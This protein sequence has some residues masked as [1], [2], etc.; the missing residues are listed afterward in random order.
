MESLRFAATLVVVAATALFTG[1]G[2][3]SAAT[4]SVD[5]D[6][7]DCPAADFSHVQAA[8]DAAGTGDT[9]AICPGT[10]AEGPG[11]PG[12]NGVTI[13]KS[14]QI[15]GA[16]ADLVTIEPRANTQAGGQIAANSPDL[17]DPVGNIITV[18]G[19][20]AFP[21]T[22]DISGVT[23]SGG[24]R[25]T[26]FP[27]G[28]NIW[29][30]EFEGGVY[31]EAGILY[32]DA[33]G[34]ISASRVTNVV[35]SERPVAESQPGGYRS[36]NLGYGIAQ[37]TAAT[38]PPLGYTPRT[39]DVAGTRIDRYNKGGLL[40]DSATGDTPPLTASGVENQASVVG[41]QIIGRNLNSPP[42]DGTG[43]GALLTT[44]TLF[45][46]DGVKV[47]AGASLNLDS[48]T[49]SQNLMAGAGSNTPA[50][51]PGAAGVRLIG[52][53]PSAAT[54]SNVLNNSYG[55][56]N[57]ELDGTTANTTDPLDAPDNFWGYPGT[58]NATNTGPDVSPG[59]LPVLPSNPVNGAVDA[60]FGSDAVHF[61]PFRPGLLADSDGYWP[62][63]DAPL[64][65]ADDPPTVSL[66]LMPDEIGPGEGSVFTATADDDFGVK[67]I[68]FYDGAEEIGSVNPPEDSVE[69][70][71]P[72][73]CGARDISAV[74]E[75]SLGQTASDTATLTV[76]DPLYNCTADPLAALESP[77]DSIEQDGTEVSASGEAEAGIDSVELFLGDRS[78][79]RLEQPGAGPFSCVVLPQG[80]DI[81]EQTLRVVITDST[82]RSATDSAD[83]TV[84]K[85]DPTGL[86]LKAKRDKKH[87]NRIKVRG[88]L[89]LPDR[90]SKGLACSGGRVNITAKRG[91]QT[92]ANKQSGLADNCGYSLGFK[93][94]KF[95]VVRKHGK[96]KKKRIKQKIRINATFPGNA[97]LTPISADRTVR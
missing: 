47:T 81:G 11:T 41:S 12:T 29:D 80:S 74:A 84:E 31:A 2:V 48:S 66:S 53:A 30:G 70:A 7:A 59:I 44:G 76:V 69:F 39:L 37:V 56:V 90:I 57:L 55:A 67:S 86:K 82:G 6:H 77:P 49:I 87:R 51:W 10:Y 52:A 32:L 79:C 15:K 95:K 85:F 35:T 43:G 96:K 54:G 91:K 58:S 83:V 88:A 25:E 8:V 20:A 97:S 22:V 17:R 36:N 3:A 42:N 34:S 40:V 45:G 33:G 16:G 21:L 68:T 28:A 19:A 14:L 50:E 46:Q 1:I 89:Q 18:Y 5:D 71:A 64:P 23:V 38:S 26:V 62:I 4:I 61:I 72:D 13:T 24:G 60:T 92:L 63:Q 73:V 78:V 75:D 94:K 9:V 93:A 65:V 27:G